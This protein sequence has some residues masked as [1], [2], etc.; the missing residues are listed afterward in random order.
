[1]AKITINENAMWVLFT[2]LLVVSSIFGDYF[3]SKKPEPAK[4]KAVIIEVI[5][6]KSNLYD[7]AK[8]KFFDGVVTLES[9]KAGYA[10]GDTILIER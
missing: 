3:T 5:D 2:L 9:I 7:D 6:G 1:M 10:V 8:V 4:E